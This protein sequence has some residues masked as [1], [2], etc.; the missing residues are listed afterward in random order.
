MCRQSDRDDAGWGMLVRGRGKHA[1][2][3]SDIATD[4]IRRDQLQ[5][6]PENKAVFVGNLQNWGGER[7]FVSV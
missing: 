2:T 1:D 6:G 3:D 5:L 7:G 4:L